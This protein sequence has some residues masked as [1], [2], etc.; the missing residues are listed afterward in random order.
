MKS[1][2]NRKQPISVSNLQHFLISRT[3]GEPLEVICV[4]LNGAWNNVV[5]LLLSMTLCQLDEV[6]STEDKSCFHQMFSK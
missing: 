5:D 2:E 3:E 1:A 6:Q 4:E